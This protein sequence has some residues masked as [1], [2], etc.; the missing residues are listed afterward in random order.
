M[1]VTALTLWILFLVGIAFYVR[2]ARHPEAKPV[3]AYLIFVI[4]FSAT[5]FVLFGALTLLLQLAGQADLLA[6]PLAAGTFLIAVFLPAFL[7]GRWQLRK[8]PMRSRQP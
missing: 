6:E 4:A 5:A 7:V 3:A 2:R 1:Y 8:P